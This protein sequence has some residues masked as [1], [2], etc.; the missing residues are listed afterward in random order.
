VASNTLLTPP[1]Q[2]IP[3]RL[4][5]SEGATASRAGLS[6]PSVYKSAQ[7]ARPRGIIPRGDYLRGAS[8]E[9]INPP[10]ASPLNGLPPLVASSFRITSTVCSGV[11]STLFVQVYT[12]GYPLRGAAVLG[13]ASLPSGSGTRA[14]KIRLHGA[15]VLGAPG[16]RF[17]LGVQPSKRALT[18]SHHLPSHRR[19]EERRDMRTTRRVLGVTLPQWRGVRVSPSWP[20]VHALRSSY[21][22]LGLHP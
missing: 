20:A 4:K 12:G 6:F 5:A 10:M 13:C 17:R 15:A 7:S 19:K 11:F 22:N 9:H 21:Y 18:K 1:D 2:V 8:R 3:I 14:K 16:R